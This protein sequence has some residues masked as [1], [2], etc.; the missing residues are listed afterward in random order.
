MSSKDAAMK[1]ITELGWSII[2]VKKTDKVPLVSWGEYADRLPTA[3][4]VEQWHRKHKDFNMGVATGNLS[5]VIIID[6]DTPEG[7]NELKRYIP[8]DIV[9][10]M[11]ST[12]SLGLHL[13]FKTPAVPISNAVRFL[14]GV[15]VRAERGYAILPPS[16]GRSGVSYEW[17]PGLSPFEVP[18]A[19][20]PSAVLELLTPRMTLTPDGLFNRGRRMPEGDLLA[21]GRRDEDLFHAA[22]AM[23]KGG[24]GYQETLDYLLILASRCDPPFSPEE[25][26]IKV[27]SAVRRAIARERN[28]DQEVV[29][30]IAD[31]RGWFNIKDLFHQ[32]GLLTRPLQ[33]IAIS[34]IN[35]LV[36][37]K[38][39]ENHTSMNGMYR[40]VQ[41]DMKSIELEEIPDPY[42]DIVWPFGIEDYVHTLPKGV[43]VISGS[44][45]S[46]KSAFMLNLARMN[47]DRFRIRYFS[48]EMGQAEIV[49]RVRKFGYPL[50]SWNVEFF[51]RAQNFADV[52]LPNDFN[53]ID[54]LEVT[55]AFY[56]VGEEIRKIFNALDTG[57]AVI[58]LQKNPGAPTGIGGYRGLEKPRLYLNM[59]PGKIEIAKGKNWANP[60]E[61]PNGLKTEFKLHNGCSF[62][63]VTEWHR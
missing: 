43:A 31:T 25:A 29:E 42:L 61:N 34:T 47:Q 1:Y 9:T 4:E 20:L 26:K 55:D 46:G 44:P 37:E 30:W 57:V 56:L 58:G 63:Q 52:L 28:I 10:P 21:H 62:R 60:M 23:I 50:N 18:V 32:N 11:C 59:E 38:H 3:D 19:E 51:E 6:I 49:T 35:R 24:A 16:I 2:P 8:D 45:N 40:K 17:L 14:P 22:N 7:K 39:I 36:Q 15:D 5:G 54:F 53:I 13:Y 33:K 12:P 27:E 48:S 41:S